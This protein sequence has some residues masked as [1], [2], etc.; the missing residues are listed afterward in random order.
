VKSGL[1]GSA[2]SKSGN[3]P[4][5]VSAEQQLA[6]AYRALRGLR[7]VMKAGR[8]EGRGVERRNGLGSAQFGALWELRASPGMKVSELA[9]MLGIHQSTASNLLDKLED[10]GLVERRRREPDQRVVRVYLSDR[11]TALLGESPDTSQ[12]RLWNALQ[13]LPDDRL[14]RLAQDLDELRSALEESAAS[15]AGSIAER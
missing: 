4:E 15:G 8:L 6:R 7:A 2:D 10:R 11:A 13:R 1:T 5:C 3:V 14:E 12:D 9:R